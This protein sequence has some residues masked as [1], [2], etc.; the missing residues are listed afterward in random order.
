VPQPVVDAEREH[1]EKP[2]EADAADLADDTLPQTAA[3]LAN[4]NRSGQRR[5]RPEPP[6]QALPVESGVLVTDEQR[7]HYQQMPR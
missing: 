3:R 6:R 7:A 5:K 2:P 1:V 4:D